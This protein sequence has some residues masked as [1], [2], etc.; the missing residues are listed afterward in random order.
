MA[1]PLYTNSRWIVDEGGRRVKLACVNW[2]SHLEVMAAEG[3][4]KQPLDAISKRIG[5]MGFNCVR[6]TWPLFMVT[7]ST[8]GSITFRKSLQ[9]L[10]LAE[11]IAGVQVNNPGLLDLPVLQVFQAVVSNL[12]DNNIMVILD[13]HISKPG[14]CCSQSDGNGF[15]GDRYFN[16]DSWLTGLTKMATMF[17]TTTNV[18]AMSL[19]NELRGPRENVGDWY[20]YMQKGA[21]AVHSA[22][23]NVL[24]IISGLS[25][26]TDLS[27]LSKSQLQLTFTDKLVFEMHWYGFSDGKAWEDGNPNQV[28]GSVTGDVMRRGGFLLDQGWPLFFS[29]FGVDQ[30]GINVNDNRFLNCFYGVAAEL[31]L[32]WALWTFQ[33]SYYFREGTTGLDE[34]YGLLDWSWCQLRNASFLQRI[35]ALQ[36]PHQGPGISSRRIYKIIFHP[37][38]GLCVVR[39]SLFEPL[40]LGPCDQTEAWSYTPQKTLVIKGTYF[41]LQ[42]DCLG[43]PAKL[44]IICSESNSKWELIS[45]SKM[46]ISS[47]LT[48]GTTVCLDID[49]D[50]NVVT[51]LCKCLSRDQSCDPSSQWFKI[52]NSTRDQAAEKLPAIVRTY[53]LQSNSTKY[54]Q[55][56]ELGDGSQAE[57]RSS[58]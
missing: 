10:G 48:N 52:I 20:R 36:S 5:T 23:P 4:N 12:G 14:W 32:D 43:E 2:S 25:F 53:P 9:N 54:G 38:T 17:N 21:E 3:L 34:K 47:M 58:Q 22:N 30:R 56:L 28:C 49:S 42:A 8:L 6:L 39:K 13:N 18:V 11:S 27:F 33:G 51:N 46:H 29:E 24:V 55:S 44:G 26:D 16:P 40:K 31:D 37:S 7:N 35:S 50:N 41:C 15:F 19:R 1:M 45:D 57:G